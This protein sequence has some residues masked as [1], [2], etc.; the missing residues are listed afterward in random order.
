MTAR[1]FNT[2]LHTTSG[3][4]RE[5]VVDLLL[6]N[7]KITT[8]RR[9]LSTLSNQYRQWEGHTADGLT[10]LNQLSA[11]LDTLGQPRLDI[12]RNNAKLISR[13]VTRATS[14]SKDS[15]LAA[16][17]LY[18]LY[19]PTVTIADIIA[20]KFSSFDSD[21]P[22]LVD[23]V[24]RQRLSRPG[25]QYVFPLNQ[26]QKRPGQ[27]QRELTADIATMLRNAGMR[28][29]ES[30]S[31]QDIT[32]MWIDRALHAGISP[33][34]LRSILS[35]VPP[36]YDFL[37]LLTYA[38]IDQRQTARIKNRIADSINDHTIR[39]FVMKLRGTVT[40]S[41]IEQQLQHDIPGIL[42]HISFYY[43]TRRLM[44]LAGKKRQHRYVPYLPGILFF[45]TH[46]DNLP[47]IF[48]HIGALAWCYRTSATPGSPYTT[49]NIGEMKQFQRHIGQFTPDVEMELIA[50]QPQAT[51]GDNVTIVGGNLYEGH[52]GQVIKVNRQGSKTTY[53]LQLTDTQYIRW[54]TVKID[55]TLIQPLTNAVASTQ[56]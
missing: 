5:W 7:Y 41:D 44:Y 1:V 36:A 11:T 15:Y 24:E 50:T 30:F 35:T 51:I 16:I 2:Y 43:P 33:V 14:G 12:V 46:R 29:A 34:D 21:C 10:A 55:S 47:V 9:Y 27:I 13:I 8:V 38:P 6:D 37:Q 26:G 52:Q 3:N 39:W 49:I 18:L 20:L 48:R 28:F 56:R 32:A 31:R 4:P 19:E 54:S 23:I 40:P 45:R 53:T 25:A 22:Q 42:R 17:F